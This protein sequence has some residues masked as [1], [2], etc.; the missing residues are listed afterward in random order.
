MKREPGLQK[1]SNNLQIIKIKDVF[2]I[3]IIHCL[4]FKEDVKSCKIFI[5][6]HIPM[7]D[8]RSD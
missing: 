6:S 1:I 4:K 8:Y 5:L 3:I 2:F 7:M